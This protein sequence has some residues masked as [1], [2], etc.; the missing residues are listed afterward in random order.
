MIFLFF[1]LPLAIYLMIL[2]RINRGPRARI[3]SGVWDFIGVL[4]AVSGILL[5]AGPAVLSGMSER[6]RLYWLYGRNIGGPH[7][8]GMMQIWFLFSVF[9]FCLVVGGAAYLLSRQRNVTS[10][11]NVETP[12]I[13]TIIGQL[14]DQLQFKPIRSGSLYLFGI[15]DPNLP[16]RETLPE[17]NQSPDTP[18]TTPNS[19]P[20][21][22]TG[23]SVMLE[24]DA[25][26]MM[27]HV[28]LRW[29]PGQ[30]LIRKEIES[31]LAKRLAEIPMEE[32]DL[33]SWLTLIGL[34]LLCFIFW[35]A[36]ALMIYNNFR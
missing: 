15:G 18:H 9:Y 5:F 31:H 28:T 36:L 19:A 6:W 22:L 30:S 14:C 32:S 34:S 12:L 8:E 16:P 10:I 13:E 4:F 25:W 17:A 24:V 7:T 23:D 35:G 26:S 1:F 21:L 3:I 29:D 11:Y 2:G 33:G 20:T 27:R